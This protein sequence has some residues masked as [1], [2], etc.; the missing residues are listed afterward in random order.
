MVAQNDVGRGDFF[1]PAYT[2]AARK[3][4]FTIASI[5]AAQASG[6]DFK[7]IETAIA[8]PD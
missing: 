5:L 3:I 6:H 1:Q 7:W 8:G 4:G 2:D